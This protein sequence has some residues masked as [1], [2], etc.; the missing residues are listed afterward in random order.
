MSFLPVCI[1]VTPCC[2][3][4]TRTPGTEGFLRAT[5]LLES[6]ICPDCEIVLMSRPHPGDSHRAKKAKEWFERSATRDENLIWRWSD[7]GALM[8]FADMPAFVEG[9]RLDGRTQRIRPDWV[10]SQDD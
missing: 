2:G 5:R 7:E 4:I 1:K 9:D 6:A 8:A 3:H 10:G